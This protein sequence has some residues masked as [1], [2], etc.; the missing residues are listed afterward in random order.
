MCQVLE[1]LLG[2]SWRLE[3]PF[4]L[5]GAKYHLVYGGSTN[6]SPA[7]DQP[8]QSRP[9]LHRARSAPTFNSTDPAWDRDF[10]RGPGPSPR[11]QSSYQAPSLVLDKS[12]NASKGQI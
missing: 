1:T 6:Y 7:M 9:S 8:G 10:V 12:Q 4:S 3:F 11:P 5:L 2:N